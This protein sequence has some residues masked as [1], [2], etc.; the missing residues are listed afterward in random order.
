VRAAFR[1]RGLEVEIAPLV[2]IPPGTRRRA[3]LGAARDK[4]GVR[5]GFREEGAHTLVDIGE[6]PVLVPAIAEA[7]P[8]LHRLA[9]SALP[10]GASAR[11]T[12]T[13]TAAGLD[14]A[15]DT[16]S[17]APGADS[18]PRLAGLAAGQGIARLMLNGDLIALGGKPA[19][20]F[21]GVDVALPADAFVQAA[22]E[23]EAIMTGLV[24]AAAAK[25]KQVADLYCG[26][27]TFT[28]PLARKAR[29]LAVD[30][31][32]AS[33]AALKDAALRAQGIK[34]IEAKVR[35]LARE[36]L[37]RNELAPFD[38]VVFDPPRAGAKAQTEALARSKVPV[39]IA[40]SCNPAT[41][42]R[43]ARILV[44]GGYRIERVTPIDQ[45]V[46]SGQVEAVA[47][48]RRQS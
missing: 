15:L 46:F 41:L 37:S 45:F 42:A 5:L 12:V 6:C 14:V 4:K 39:V 47:V 33:I 30:G 10:P 3:V 40:V 32:R 27:G 26:V 31:N 36:P 17:P 48:L 24:V 11:L 35:D 16:E 9:G 25:A 22:P 8:A 43:D 38:A 2:A 28:F 13:A 1:H 23:A 18:A 20:T 19:L 7:L 29:V 44:D 21:A 34:A